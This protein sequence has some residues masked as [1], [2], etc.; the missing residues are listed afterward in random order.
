MYWSATPSLGE[1]GMLSSTP[2]N[3][4]LVSIGV[5]AA[6]YRSYQ[7]EQFDEGSFQE[8]NMMYQF[9]NLSVFIKK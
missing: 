8:S 4:L 2:V 3:S 6:N 5:D 9:S 1:A 7:T